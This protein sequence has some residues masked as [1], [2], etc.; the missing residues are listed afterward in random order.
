MITSITIGEI[1]V[2]PDEHRLTN[3][4][5]VAESL[6]PKVIEVFSFM[7]ANYP[8]LISRTEIIDVVWDG[9][10]YVGDKALTNAIWQL[11]QSLKHLSPDF[12]FI[13]TVRKSGYKLLVEPKIIYSRLKQSS[14]NVGKVN[15]RLLLPVVVLLLTAF[16]GFIFVLQNGIDQKLF[17]EITNV[18]TEPGREVLASPSPNGQLLAFKWI[19]QGFSDDL[20]IKNINQPRQPFRQV[21]FDEASETRPVWSKDGKFLY[22][23][24]MDRQAIRCELVKLNLLSGK[25]TNLASCPY[26]DLTQIDISP[27]GQFLAYRGQRDASGGTGIYLLNI[28]EEQGIPQKLTCIPSCNYQD[29][30]IA[31]SPDGSRIAISRR[32]DK[33]HE[34]IVVLD[35]ESKRETQITD[36]FKDMNGLTWHPNGK[37]I[38]FAA[39]QADQRE[40][41]VVDIDELQVK[42]L[43]VRG[44]SFPHF[45]KQGVLY[46]HERIEKYQ[47]SSV[48]L[49]DSTVR[50]IQPLVLSSYSHK[51]PDYSDVTDQ[52]VYVSNESGS[53]EL[54]VANRDGSNR[55]QLTDIKTEIS[56][57]AWS[58]DGRSIAFIT[59]KF[60]GFGDQLNIIDINSG[61]IRP[62]KSKFSSLGRPSW[63]FDD[64]HVLSAVYLPDKTNIFAFDRSSEEAKQVTKANG[65]YAQAFKPEK[66]VYTKYDG[67]LWVKLADSDGE[68]L[69][70]DRNNFG[71]KYVWDITDRGIFFYHREKQKHQIRFF[72]FESKAFL[73]LFDLPWLSDDQYGSLSVSNDSNLL[74][75]TASE[76]PQADIK[77]LKHSL[78]APWTDS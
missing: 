34:D 71:V 24:K 29:R 10:H 47:I 70:L 60:E 16:I 11:R 22:F 17:S 69:F 8:R 67:S 73:A 64:Q 46:Y 23:F 15:N 36:N 35:I 44:F 43:G 49:S 65:R 5:G 51:N 66:I 55:Q 62:I 38:V 33:I 68:N 25:Q 48:D 53:Y 26:R 75:L 56:Y 41:F 61:K 19:R 76:F 57:P 28:L 74:F 3:S 18:T 39:Q 54:W 7:A 21:T 32:V 9:N 37:Q 45:S 4:S 59:P 40:G 31:F 30:D 13:E 20:F 72:D 27:N 77:T 78:I 14:A 2:V 6:Q 50:G 63:S 1:S 52:L 12:E 42:S 58:H